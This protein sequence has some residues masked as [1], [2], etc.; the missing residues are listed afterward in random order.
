MASHDYHLVTPS[1]WP[2][3]SGIAA[4]ILA[5]GA[6]VFMKWQLSWLLIGGGGAVAYC[7][8]MWCRD[9]IAEAQTEGVHTSVVQLGLR[10]GFMLFILSEIMFFVAW[11]WS[12]FNSALLP[13][14]ATSA[15][16]PPE[17]IQPIDPFDWPLINTLILLL[18]GTTVTWAHHCLLENNRKDFLKGLLLT[19][20]LGAAFTG[21]QLWEYLHAS[22]KFQ[23]GIYSSV[24]YM[25][26]GF[27]GAHVIAGTVFLGVCFL[28]ALRGHFTPS[29]HFG[30]EAAAW[31]WHFV[32]VVWLFLFFMIYIWGSG[33]A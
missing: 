5:L 33:H 1:C 10:Y 9:V 22:F 26:T 25:A 14:E 15:F 24:F 6:L 7:A 11:F 27:H 16:W 17:G 8:F 28:R 4:F 3:L 19:I 21:I 18:S 12:F 2:L 31:Y 32:D 23:D 29:Q 20:L 30:F 13:L